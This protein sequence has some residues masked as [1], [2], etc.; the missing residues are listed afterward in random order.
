ML[1][2]YIMKVNKPIEMF[3]P[4]RH[5]VHDV[6]ADVVYQILETHWIAEDKVQLYTMLKNRIMAAFRSNFDD[7]NPKPSNDW[8]ADITS[9]IL[10]ALEVEYSIYTH[11]IDRNEETSE[12]TETLSV[13]KF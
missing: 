12:E 13:T 1:R 4:M 10:D 8:Y 5:D 11:D 9:E 6:A 2:Q 3:C 7:C